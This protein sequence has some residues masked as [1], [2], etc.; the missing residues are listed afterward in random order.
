MNVLVE[1]RYPKTPLAGVGAVVVGRKGVLLVRREKDPGRGLW[2]IPG[3]VIELGETHRAA[4]EREI[5][6]ETGI[7]IDLHELLGVIDVILPDDKGNIEYHGLMICYLARAL[8]EDNYDETPEGEVG[9]FSPDALISLELHPLM[10]MILTDYRQ[11]IEALYM[12]MSDRT[13]R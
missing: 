13:Q 5:L 1:R 2:S 8:N 6:E 7:D 4:T 10:K 9:W 11:D 12:E 3:G